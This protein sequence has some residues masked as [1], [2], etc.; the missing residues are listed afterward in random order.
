MRNIH[1]RSKSFRHFTLALC[2]L[3]LSLIISTCSVKK[4]VCVKDFGGVQGK[5][6]VESSAGECDIIGGIF[7]EDQTCEELGL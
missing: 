1:S 6:C 7:Y 3:L 2:V 4:G 5:S